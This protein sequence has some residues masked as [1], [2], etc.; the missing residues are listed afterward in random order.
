MLKIIV[1]YKLKAFKKVYPNCEISKHRERGF[2][3]YDGKEY[4]FVHGKGELLY[5]FGIDLFKHTVYQP[6]EVKCQSDE[7]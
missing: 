2:I 4:H 5:E 1:V 3:V 6:K 7:L